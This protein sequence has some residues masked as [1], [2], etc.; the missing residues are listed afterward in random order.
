[1]VAVPVA[2]TVPR[3]VPVADLLGV[4][5]PRQVLPGPRFLAGVAPAMVVVVVVVVKAAVEVVGLGAQVDDHGQRG[6]NCVVVV[7]GGHVAAGKKQRCK[8][9]GNQHPVHVRSPWSGSRYDAAFPASPWLRSISW[10]REEFLR[11]RV[12]KPST[13]GLDFKGRGVRRGLCGTA[14]VARRPRSGQAGGV[15]LGA[16]SGG[17]AVSGGGV[18][19]AGAFLR[20]FSA[21]FFFFSSS[22]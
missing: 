5:V 6:D 22:L 18:S 16:V 17:T 4:V 15:Q 12:S 10:T 20:S 13:R 3:A 9:R 8:Q 7:Y 14:V 19:L 1:M 21:F 11:G 2:V